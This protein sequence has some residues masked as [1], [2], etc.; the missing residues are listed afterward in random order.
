VDGGQDD[1]LR[2]GCLRGRKEKLRIE[3]ARKLMR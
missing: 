1:D 3:D 2:K